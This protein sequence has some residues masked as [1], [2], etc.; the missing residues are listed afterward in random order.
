MRSVL[1]QVA[2]VEFDPSP[3]LS[4]AKGE[5]VPGE[6]PSGIGVDSEEEVVLIG[7]DLD[8]AIEVAALE[9]RLED[10]GFVDGR[11]HAFKGAVVEFIAVELVMRHVVLH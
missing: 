3:V 9:S 10:E 4:I 6:V 1:G 8:G 11:V 2:D 7:C 5:V